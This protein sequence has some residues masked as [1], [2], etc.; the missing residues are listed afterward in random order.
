MDDEAASQQLMSEARATPHLNDYDGSAI[1]LEL[2]GPSQDKAS[3]SK[4]SRQRKAKKPTEKNVALSQTARVRETRSQPPSYSPDELRAAAG[5]TPSKSQTVP[6]TAP[7]SQIKVP[8]TQLEI[9]AD[10]ASTPTHSK[11][12]QP[13]SSGSQK[14]QP[15]KNN[16][17]SRAFAE[18]DNEHVVTSTSF[19]AD[20]EAKS[21]SSQAAGSQAT[22][23]RR[24]KERSRNSL[25]DV[26]LEPTNVSETPAATQEAGS[27]V[28]GADID[29]RDGALDEEE[30]ALTPSVLLGKLNLEKSQKAQAGGKTTS[31]T[32]VLEEASEPVDVD[33]AIAPA[34]TANGTTQDA[35]TKK[36]KKTKKNKKEAEAPDVD[37][38][39]ARSRLSTSEESS[40]GKTSSQK[41]K[42]AKKT[43]VR[44]SVGGIKGKAIISKA[45]PNKMYQRASHNN[46]RTAAD[47][48]LEDA[49]ELGHPPDKRTSG[50]Y[51]ADEK[52]LLRRAIRDHQERNGLDTADLV[53]IIHW[54]DR[55]RVKV[56]ESATAQAEAQFQKDCDAFWDEINSAGLLRKLRDVKRHVRSRYHLHQRGQWSQEED[57]Q[58]RELHNLHPGQWKLIATHLNRLEKD[59][60][61]RW[62]DYVRHG[63]NRVTKRW[64]ADE[65]H[66]FVAVLSAVCQKIEDYRAETGQPPLDDY[67]PFINW[68]EVCKKM[69][70]TRSRLQCQS[71]WKLMCAREPPAT[72]DIE[73]KPRTAMSQVQPPTD[74]ADRPRKPKAKKDRQSSATKTNPDPPGSD[75]MLWGDKMDLVTYL[76]EQKLLNEFEWSDQIIWQD[77][78][79]RMGPI[80]STDTIQNAYEQL[81]ELVLGE[82]TDD[83]SLALGSIVAYI[84]TNHN[85]K[86]NERY[87][88]TQKLKSDG[89][90]ASNVK[91]SKKSKRQAGASSS[92]ASAKKTSKA[93]SSSTKAFKSQE[94]IE[95]SGPEM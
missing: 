32:D 11:A 57:E 86:D 73:I 71:K 68:H 61:A 64:T 25:N 35:G 65:E 93:P 15:K 12:K 80:W 67:Y 38:G 44:Y 78:A 58:L 88:P 26:E 79:K 54:T 52:E 23:K 2:D 55:S 59:T 43:K 20:G 27:Q 4:T 74:T 77:V 83:L 53:E 3:V 87:D 89:E 95:D 1:P 81:C 34:S 84:Q 24:R 50:D 63:E 16:K 29:G 21:Q 60:Y 94:L 33:L 18:L 49:H 40:K 69:D 36:K 62:R 48:A 6:S 72:L 46:D 8:N 91:S 42:A 92:K 41:E 66:N 45:D 19:E 14:A 51:T 13:A 39:E 75:D 76:A 85:D 47:S 37:D 70:D 9:Q 5:D 10:A 31:P 56:S 28:A 82:P 90:D 22:R 7:S 30:P 17:R